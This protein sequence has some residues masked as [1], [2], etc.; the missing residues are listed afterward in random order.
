M[1]GKS[2]VSFWRLAGFTVL[3]I[4]LISSPGFSQGIPRISVTEAQNRVS[5]GKALLVCSYEDQYCSNLMLTGAL[6]RSQLDEKLKSLPKNTE[7]IFYCA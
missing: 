7:I 3:F 4:V 6:L 5:S 2:R 1:K